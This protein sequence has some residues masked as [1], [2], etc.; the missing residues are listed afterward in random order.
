MDDKKQINVT[1]GNDHQ[2]TFAN[3]INVSVSDDAV[4]LQFLFI[5]PNTDQAKL[6]SEVILTPKHAI[7]FQKTLDDT[8]KKHFTRH[9]D[10]NKQ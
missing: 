7:S 8:I 4:A 2:P 10:E 3:S 6:V 9:L 5:R 1:V